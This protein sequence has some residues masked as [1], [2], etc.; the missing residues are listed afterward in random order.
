VRLVDQHQVALLDVPGAAVDR[1]NAGEEDARPEIAPAEPG[2]VD[3]GRRVAPEAD[4][5]G[6]VLRDQLADVGDDEDALIGPGLQH[7]LD[8]GRHHQTLAA[9]GRNHDERVAGVLGEVAVDRVD[10]GL[11]VGAERQHATASARASLTQAPP[12]RMR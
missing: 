7:A 6:V 9:G 3:A 5:L 2:G 4:Q 8:E 1:L 11:L 10:R 12:S